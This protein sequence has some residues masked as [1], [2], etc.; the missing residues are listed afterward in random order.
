MIEMHKKDVFFD[1]YICDLLSQD[2][3]VLKQLVDLEADL[4]IFIGLKRRDP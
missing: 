4:G 3:F 1:T 2:R